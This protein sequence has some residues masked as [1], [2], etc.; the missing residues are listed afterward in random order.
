MDTLTHCV[1]CG[2]RLVPTLS[3]D[4]RTELTCIWCDNVDPVQ[5][6]AVKWADSP[7]AQQTT[8]PKAP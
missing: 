6:E 2:K 8:A 7:L 1:H 5:T 3:P 4:G